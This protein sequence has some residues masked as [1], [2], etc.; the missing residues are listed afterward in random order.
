[1][2]RSLGCDGGRREEFSLSL[3]EQN[4]ERVRTSPFTIIGLFCLY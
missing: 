3:I 1:M 4:R 2:M